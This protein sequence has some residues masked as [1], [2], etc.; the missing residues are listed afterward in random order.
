MDVADAVDGDLKTLGF[1]KEGQAKM[2][3][4]GST[5][6]ANNQYFNQFFNRDFTVNSVDW[7]AGEEKS[8]SIRPR[9]MHRFGLPS[10]G[11]G[12]QAGFCALSA[13]VARDAVDFGNRGVVGAAQL[14]ANRQ[15]PRASRC[16]T[17]G[18]GSGS[19]SPS[20][21]LWERA[22]VRVLIHFKMGQTRELS[23]RSSARNA[24]LRQH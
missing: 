12:V 5:D 14:N 1:A 11:A 10:D 19:S 13:A 24:L 9:T 22:E 2:V 23:G 17:A 21:R 15:S 18:C 16:F 4:I 3:V 20:N 8:I 6:F 7:L